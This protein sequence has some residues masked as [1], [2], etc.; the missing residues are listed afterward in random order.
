M[1]AVLQVPAAV[2]LPLFTTEDSAKDDCNP[3]AI[4]GLL[5]QVPYVQGPALAYMH[6]S[7]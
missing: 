1:R 6:A 4:T 2:L 5:R 3:G 7:G